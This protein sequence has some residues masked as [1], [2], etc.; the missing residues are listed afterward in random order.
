[1]SVKYKFRDQEKLYFVSFSVVYWIDVFIRNEY[2]EILLDSLRFCQKEKGLEVYAWCIMTSHVH[3][4]I[5]T[6]G[7]KMQDI[8]RDLKSHTSRELK[9]AIRGNTSESRKEW[10]LRIMEESGKANGNNK[11]FQFW[12]QDNHPIELWDNYM[13]EQKLDYLHNN[14]IEAGFVSC[15][16]DYVYSSAKD[17]CG[18]K[19]LLEIK[20]IE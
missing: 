3:L 2:K 1:M 5:G 4:I 6:H 13:L 17:Y 18:E 9:K 10:M 7:A 16:Q 20:L 12:Q 14:P 11:D 15:I 8:M 19:G